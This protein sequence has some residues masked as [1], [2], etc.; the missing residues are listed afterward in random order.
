V[1]DGTATSRSGGRTASVSARSDR[2]NLYFLELGADG[3]VRLTTVFSLETPS[4]RLRA[5]HTRTGRAAEQFYGDCAVMKP[6]S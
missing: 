2:S 1:A 4:G 3:I 6:G 5:A